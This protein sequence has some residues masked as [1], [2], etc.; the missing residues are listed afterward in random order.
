MDFTMI[1]HKS[2][3]L[4]LLT[5]VSL[6][7]PMAAFAQQQPPAAPPMAEIAVAL[8]VSEEA[9]AA[10]FPAQGKGQGQGQDQGKPERPDA[11]KIT[12]CLQGE[13]PNLSQDTVTQ[14]L[15]KFAPKP[16]KN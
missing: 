13:N 15:E 5:A 1:R 7:A 6:V 2:K 16:P 3:F 11:A 8:G 9:V 12:E 4:S 14:T 10:C